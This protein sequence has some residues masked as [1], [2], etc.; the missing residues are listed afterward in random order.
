MKRNES[1]FPGAHDYTGISGFGFSA[2]LVILVLAVWVA[3]TQLI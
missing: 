2:V 3:W 1:E